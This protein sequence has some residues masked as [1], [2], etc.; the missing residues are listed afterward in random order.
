[1]ASFSLMCS[2]VL[3]VHLAN[4]ETVND[5]RW[6]VEPS[7]WGGTLMGDTYQPP[8]RTGT[9]KQHDKVGR[10]QQARGNETSARVVA[11]QVRR[12]GSKLNA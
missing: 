6:T 4:A 2:L 8:N 12:I 9:G 3:S 1:M 7:V 10:V 11:N 5:Y